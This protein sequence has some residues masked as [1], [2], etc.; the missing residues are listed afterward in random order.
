MFAQFPKSRRPLPEEYRRILQSHYLENREGRG[1]SSLVHAMESWLH[2]AVAR[3][4]GEPDFS[5]PVLEI[6]AGTLNHLEYEKDLSRG[7]DVV[8][9]ENYLLN[10]VPGRRDR[11]RSV[12]QDIREVPLQAR[13]SR[14]VSIATLEHLTDLPVVV[15]RCGQILDREGL[16]QAAIP[17]EGSVLWKIGYTLTNGIAF[18]LRYGLDYEVIMR[19]EHVNFADEIEHVL[20]YFFDRVSCEF[21]GPHKSFSFYRAYQCRGPKTAVCADFLKHRGA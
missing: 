5:G 13:Y 10:H 2:R 12:F 7:Y 17:S 16:F 21:F 18:R 20:R 14:I 19:H 6:G 8:E 4:Q 1:F 9:P 11:V 3:P 15:A